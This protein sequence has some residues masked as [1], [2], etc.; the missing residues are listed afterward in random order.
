MVWWG[1]AFVLIMLLVDLATVVKGIGS[2]RLDP[3]QPG[4]VSCSH[5]EKTVGQSIMGYILENTQ[6][7]AKPFLDGGPHWVV[8]HHTEKATH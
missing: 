8:V 3:L 6:Q 2:I 4:N 7:Q 1:S 5:S